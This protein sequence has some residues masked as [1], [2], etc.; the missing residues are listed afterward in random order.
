[1]KIGIII[2]SKTNNTFSVA[3]RLQDALVRQ[4]CDAVI[5]RIIP[6]DEDP[7]PKKPI[8]FRNF[9]DVSAYDVII[10][11]SPVWAFSLSW[12]M[13]AYLEQIATLGGKKVFAFV[14]KQMASKF[15]GGNKAIRSIKSAVV[16]KDANLD[17]AFIIGWNSKNREELIADGIDQI[18]KAVK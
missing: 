3:Q 7:D 18:V 1:M 8:T 5:D 11:G 2:Y 4:G 10:F 17:A 9:P 13:K 16:A 12:V 15:T 6:V 14:T